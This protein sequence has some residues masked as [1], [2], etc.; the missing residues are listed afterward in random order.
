MLCGAATLV[1]IAI[2]LIDTSTVAVEMF[3]DAKKCSVCMTLLPQAPLS[4]V[5]MENES[6]VA[7]F[8]TVLA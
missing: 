6:V 2:V 7:I 4:S 5:L 8:K 3:F 1:G